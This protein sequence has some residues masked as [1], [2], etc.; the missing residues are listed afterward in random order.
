MLNTSNAKLEF[1]PF[2][3]NPGSA[4][5]LRHFIAWWL[6]FNDPSWNVNLKVHL[7]LFF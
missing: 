5:A 6:M 2:T 3:Q 7:F 1:R 4:A